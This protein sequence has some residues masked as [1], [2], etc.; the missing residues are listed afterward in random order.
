MPEIPSNDG[1]TW[2]RIR[3]VDFPSKFV[4]EPN[5][6]NEYKK[7]TEIPEK[8]KLWA[9]YFISLLVEMYSK[10]LKEGLKEPESVIKYTKEYQRRSDVYLDYIEENLIVTENTEDVMTFSSLYNHFKQWHV[11]Y[12]NEKP[13]KVLFKEYMERKYG[14]CEKRPERWKCMKFQ[15]YDE[16]VSDVEL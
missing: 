6:P 9:P 2:R 13:S 8:L 5:G 3:V 16:E 11:E 1:G 15:V 7:D 4:D 14:K 10:F 12:Y